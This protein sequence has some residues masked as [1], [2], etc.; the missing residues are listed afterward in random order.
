M[1]KGWISGFQPSSNPRTV[2]NLNAMPRLSQ[3]H[4]ILNAEPCVIMKL[5]T[6]LLHFLCAS[7]FIQRNRDDTN[8][9]FCEK[10][11]RTKK[12]LKCFW[13]VSMAFFL[14]IHST[15]DT[16]AY[17]FCLIFN[18]KWREEEKKIVYCKVGAR[19]INTTIEQYKGKTPELKQP[20]KK[21]ILTEKKTERLVKAIF[22][23][24]KCYTFWCWSL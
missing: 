7:L 10:S 12:Y 21:K 13:Y 4:S 18:L 14:S 1:E 20:N 6:C 8:R 24:R 17:H 2:L 15:N 5:C 16:M 3:F 11:S 23:F 19:S 22:Q 9:D